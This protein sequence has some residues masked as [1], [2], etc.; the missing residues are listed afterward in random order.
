MVY[1]YSNLKK[2][3]FNHKTFGK[4]SSLKLSVL[5]EFLNSNTN[6]KILR[7]CNIYNGKNTGLIKIYPTLNQ[8]EKNFLTNTDVYRNYIHIDD[9]IKIVSKMLSTNLKYNIY[10]IGNENIKL[11]NIL[12]YIEK[13]FNLELII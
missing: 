2:R 11:I 1:G 8:E 12:K 3:D 5:G 6:F 13:K 7:L 9:C 10:N 4:D